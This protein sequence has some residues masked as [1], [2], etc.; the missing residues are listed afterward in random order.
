[1]SLVLSSAIRMI[2]DD[3]SG[4]LL[5]HDQNTG[6]RPRKIV[7]SPFSFLPH[8]MT[9]APVWERFLLLHASILNILLEG[10]TISKML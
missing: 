8:S 9:S 10:N 7:L 6:R 1:M 3:P 2:I 4:P 5:H